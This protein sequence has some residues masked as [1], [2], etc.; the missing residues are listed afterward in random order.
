MPVTSR[1]LIIVSGVILYTLCMKKKRQVF[2][3]INSRRQ[4]LVQ[5]TLVSV[6]K[7]VVGNFCKPV[8]SD[9]VMPL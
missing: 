4:L 7:V 5:Q 8:N 6:S 2:G 3:M 9:Q 1:N